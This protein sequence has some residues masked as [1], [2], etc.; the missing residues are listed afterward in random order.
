M[1][2][3]K[4]DRANKLFD[5]PQKAAGTPADEQEAA[6]RA[7]AEKT[8]RLRALRLARDAAQAAEAAARGAASKSKARAKSKAD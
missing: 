3:S 6:R 8:A 2:R 7:I 5:K 1:S 4:R